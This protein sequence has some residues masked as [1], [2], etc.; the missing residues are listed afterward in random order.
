MRNRN[1]SQQDREGAN[2]SRFFSQ[3]I[4]QA[5]YAIKNYH[6]KQKVKESK[7][8]T[9]SQYDGRFGRCY[10]NRDFLEKIKWH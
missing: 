4:T 3:Q 1:N 5:Q 2:Y 6:A 7:S 9:P 10:R 8:N